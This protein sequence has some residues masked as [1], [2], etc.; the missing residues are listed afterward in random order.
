VIVQESL[1]S[2]HFTI[3]RRKAPFT[4]IKLYTR[5]LPGNVRELQ[6]EIMRLITLSEGECRDGLMNLS[7]KTFSFDMNTT[8]NGSALCG[9]VA[10]Y[11]K[12]LILKTLK[13][14]KI[15]VTTLK[16]KIR[17]HRIDRPNLDAD[18]PFLDD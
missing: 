11:E 13:A 8:E 16:N 6:N 7:D 18:R 10:E 5:I 3:R 15:P 12:K 14:L 2:R 9:L 4:T 17:L 1:T